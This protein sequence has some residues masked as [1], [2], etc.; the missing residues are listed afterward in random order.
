MKAPLP[1]ESARLK[2]EFPELT[3]DDLQAYATVTGQVLG[4]P[5]T[6]G[7]KMREVMGRA[8]EAQQKAAADH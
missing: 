7:K 6:R 5:A 3:E 2:A 1:V 8:R 4:D